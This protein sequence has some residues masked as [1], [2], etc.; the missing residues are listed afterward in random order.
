MPEK[1]TPEKNK[2]TSS[3]LQARLAGRILTHAK[4][5]GF[6]PGAWLSENALAQAF[7]VSRT[8]VRGALAVL[9]K[10]GLVNAVPRRGYVLKRAVRDQDLEPYA[11]TDNQDDR[12]VERMAGDRFSGSLPD[13]VSEADLM[14]RYGVAR[15]ALAR[16]LNRLS[17]DSVI[18]RRDGHGWRFLPTLDTTQLHDESYRYRLLIEPAG[19]LEPTFRLEIA[20][21]QRLREEHLALLAGGWKQMSSVKFFELNASFHEFVAL[22]SGNRFFHQ[23][24]VHQNRLRRFFS[25]NW[26]YGAE[27][28]RESSNEHVAILDRLLGGDREQAATL[29]RLHLLGASRIR[30][31]FAAG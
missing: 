20:R 9:S 17:Q 6:G 4:D 16:V 13:Q 10:R 15:G 29:L 7:G 14:R 22:C 27:R 5:H 26:V 18:E 11:D 23:S 21:A 12:L 19:V 28:M 30:P 24:I 1:H 3:R 31:N 25:Y 2:T 8:P